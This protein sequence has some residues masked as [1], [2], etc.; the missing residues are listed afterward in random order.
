MS[1]SS[2]IDKVCCHC[3]IAK[4]C[5]T[6]CDPMDCRMQ[7]PLSS[8]VSQSLL[9]FMSIELVCHLTISS[10]AAPFSFCLQSCP[11][12]GSFPV[13]Q[14]FTSGGQNIG[15][16][17]SASILPMYIQGWVPLGLTGLISLNVNYF[18]SYLLIGMKN[19]AFIKSIAT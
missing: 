10:S 4:L 11:A 6:V 7:A 8:T 2:R 1:I 15:A 13:S 16:L 17:T 19:N 12:S 9:R 3:S 14:F 5:L 18:W